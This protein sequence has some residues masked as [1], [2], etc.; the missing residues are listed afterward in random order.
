MV[1]W[2]LQMRVTL[3]SAQLEVGVRPEAPLVSGRSYFN[4]IWSICQMWGVELLIILGPEGW[5]QG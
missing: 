4:V 2:I 1:W 3:V 5:I